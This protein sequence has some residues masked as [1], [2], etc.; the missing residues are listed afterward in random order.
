MLL[1]FLIVS[2]IFFISCST[3]GET[4]KKENI[5]KENIKKENIKKELPNIIK[6]NC[7]KGMCEIPEGEFMMGCNEASSAKCYPNVTSFYSIGFRCA[8]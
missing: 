7:S 2:S 6:A 3:T 1:S 5:K 8:K 4:I